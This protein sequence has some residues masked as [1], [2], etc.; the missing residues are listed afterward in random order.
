MFKV[1]KNC[2]KFSGG[3]H[4]YQEV[5]RAVRSCQILSNCV[6]FSA[7]AGKSI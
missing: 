3:V 2:P 7:D 5:S 6:N 4:S 1:V